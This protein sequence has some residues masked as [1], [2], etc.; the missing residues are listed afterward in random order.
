VDEEGRIVARQE[1]NMPG[2]DDFSLWDVLSERTQ[3]NRW[4]FPGWQ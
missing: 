2:P 4:F 1:L 3:R